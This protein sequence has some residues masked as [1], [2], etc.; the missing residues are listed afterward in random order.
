VPEKSGFF[1]ST[2]DDMREYPARDFAEY[3]AR[4]V[5]N[6]VFNGG[7]YLN[8]TASGQDANISLSPGAAW[9]NGYAYGVYDSSLVL[10]IEP[11]AALDRID[12]IILR[13]DTSTP[14]RA[15]RALVAQGLPASNPTPPALVRSG[16]IYDLSIAQVR[17]PA[18]ST[19]ITQA[20][21]TDERL[22]QDVCG[23]VNSLIRVDTAI[24]QE[25]WDDFIQSVQNQG[26]VTT[27]KFN[28]HLA[29]YIR[30]PGFAMTEGTSTTYTVTLDPAPITLQDGFGITIVPHVTNGA[31]PT[32]KIG[33]STALP[34]KD[35]K[36]NAY[37]AG[38]LLVGKPYAFRKVG[39][40]FL[41]DSGSG[42]EGDA[43]ANDLRAGKKATIDTGE[44]ITGTLAEQTTTSI[45]PSTTTQNFP[46]GIYPA[47]TVRAAPKNANRGTITIPAQSATTI[48][49]GVDPGLAVVSYGNEIGIAA[50]TYSNGGLVESFNDFA[51]NQHS[52]YFLLYNLSYSPGNLYV[53]SGLGVAGTFRYLVVSKF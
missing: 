36:G 28:T 44:V 4:F 42:A 48:P 14:V 11:A 8:P 22:N 53:Y 15:I 32:L 5:T 23:L 10:P 40:D 45:T 33:T 13:L 34:L 19:I 20:N 27:T 35:Q 31:N 46:A 17:V 24:F 30:Q 3:F 51:F 41:A 9:I 39:S 26:F 1:D 21:I 49:T 29:D 12:R 47:F 18:N 7:Q 38:K 16:N 43:T 37:T 6:G 2:A 50:R 52:D 25:Q